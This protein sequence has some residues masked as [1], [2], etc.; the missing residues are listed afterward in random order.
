VLKA[1]IKG[2]IFYGV[3]FVCWLFLAPFA[4]VIPGLQQAVQI[5]VGVYI[6]LLV[7]GELTAGTIYQHFFGVASDLFM[8]SYLILA[9]NSGMF[10]MT[11]QNVALQVDLRLFLIIATMLSFIGLSKTIL[12]AI[13]FVSKKAENVPI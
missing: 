8:I 13:N 4:K 10:S 5:F 11:Y 6:G 9:L 12:Q 1:T 2:L 3:Y 7:V